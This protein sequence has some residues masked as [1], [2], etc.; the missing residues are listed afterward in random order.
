MR[1]VNQVG[2]QILT[3]LEAMRPLVDHVLE[4]DRLAVDLTTLGAAFGATRAGTQG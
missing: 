2:R 3:A 1:S 4:R